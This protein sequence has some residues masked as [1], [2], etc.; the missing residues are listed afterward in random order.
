MEPIRV[1]IV[2]DQEIVRV[3]LR[4]LLARDRDIRVVGVASSGQEALDLLDELRPQVLIV[5]Y[6][7]DPVGGV[8]VC[9]SVNANHPEIAVIML[10]TFMDDEVVQRSVQAGAKAFV[11]KDVEGQ[12]LKRI[13]RMVAEGEPVPHPRTTGHVM[14]WPGHQLR[15]VAEPALSSRERE[16]LGLVAQ[17]ASNAQ[18][19]QTLGLSLNSVK[20]FLRRASAKLGCHSRA[21]AVA[22]ASRR[23]LL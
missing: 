5:D 7:L 18:I 3:G 16:V 17:G 22:A 12:D 9:E 15:R 13:V 21:E 8:E 6:S 20:T 14:R 10:S 11:Y 23:G 19:A 2:D 4:T 1:L